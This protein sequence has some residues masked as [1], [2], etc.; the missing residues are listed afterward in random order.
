MF[1]PLL[2]IVFPLVLPPCLTLRTLLDFC[3]ADL[4]LFDVLGNSFNLIKSAVSP[5]SAAQFPGLNGL[6]ISIAR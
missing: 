1:L 6:G 4:T 2:F 5:G 3:V